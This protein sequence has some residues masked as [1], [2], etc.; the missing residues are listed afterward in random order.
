MTFQ[1]KH[2]PCHNK[3]NHGFGYCATHYRQKY[4]LGQETKDVQKPVH[5][6][7]D[8]CSYD[9]CDRTAKA[10]GL[11]N[12]HWAQVYKYGMEARPINQF[13]DMTCAAPWCKKEYR[14][15]SEHQ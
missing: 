14:T 10:K 2:Q 7:G 12:T 9:G 6:T 13:I 15:N 1:C 8:K 5:K 11:C 3:K 4:V